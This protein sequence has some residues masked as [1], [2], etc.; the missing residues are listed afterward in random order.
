MSNNLA[1]EPS[2]TCDLLFVILILVL[3]VIGYRYLL[4]V[5]FKIKID[6]Y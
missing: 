1:K 4:S 3:A 6:K 2:M 5:I